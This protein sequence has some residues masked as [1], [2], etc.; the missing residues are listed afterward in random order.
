VAVSELILL[1]HAKSDWR[2][3][4][5]DEDRPLSRRGRQAA[6]I[7]GRVLTLAGKAPD[8]V[9]TSPA[10]RAAETARLAA[11]AGAWEAPIVTRQSLLPGSPAEVLAAVREAAGEA[12]R[13]LVVGHEPTCS[14]TAAALLGGGTLR[15]AT[16]AAACI[17]FASWEEL[18]RGQGVLLWMLSPRLFTEGAFPLE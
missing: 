1:R 2:V 16:A 18:G 17:E 12:Q 15:M 10:L 8:L 7:M 11:E 4:T 9:L 6:R 3:G 5:T 14:E 13:V